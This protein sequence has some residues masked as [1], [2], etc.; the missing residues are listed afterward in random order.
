[1]KQPYR[2]AIIGT[3]RIAKFH[4]TGYKADPRFQ[5]VALADVREEA[6]NTF[7]T[8]HGLNAKVYTD[9]RKLLT[10]EKPDIVSICL[11]P[12]LHLEAVR[13]CVAAGV[14]AIHCEKPIAANW[15]EAQDV[16][17]AVKGTGTQLT[18]NHQRRLEPSYVRAHELIQEGYIG[19]LERM[20]VYI[21]INLLD[22]GT[23][24]MDI[25]LMLNG[26]SPAKWVMAQT[27]VRQVQAWFGVPF[28]FAAVGEMRFEN[29]VRAI[30]HSGDDCGMPIF[31]LR[32]IGTG[33]MIELQAETTIRA[34]QF[35]RGTWEI[36]APG[37]FADT[38]NGDGMRAVLDDILRGVEEGKRPG[39]GVENA[40]QTTELIFAIFE[41]SRRRA[42]I[43][44]PLTARDAGI[45]SLLAACRA[46][47]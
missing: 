27:D 20:E 41:S 38:A 40:M 10:D 39:V 25:M 3:G 42:R 44:L 14:R 29:G 23:H 28:E 33:G 1:M 16:A 43:D 26:Q 21:H 7:K 18:F 4:I 35:G 2:A 13:A 37:V 9:Y 31:S 36:P 19:K 24:I 5:V 47:A 46:S 17:A 11:W 8:T 34:M 45:D 6:A 30:L 22:M 12:H 32:L 15:G